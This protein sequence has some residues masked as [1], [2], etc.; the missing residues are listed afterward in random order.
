MMR[1]SVV[2]ETANQ[3]VQAAW[4]V[5]PGIVVVSKTTAYSTRNMLVYASIHGSFLGDKLS[6]S[7]EVSE[8]LRVAPDMF[9]RKAEQQRAAR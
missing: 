9:G 6:T 8:H 4:C 2:A 5:S 3:I 7:A 1:L